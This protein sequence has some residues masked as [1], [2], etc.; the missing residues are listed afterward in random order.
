MS[1]RRGLLGTLIVLLGNLS[2]M[3]ASP[4]KVESYGKVSMR[5]KEITHL[6]GISGLLGWDEMV[7]LPSGSSGSRSAQKEVLAGVLYDKRA[8]PEL[9]SLLSD[10]QGA[11]G[12]DELSDVQKANVRIALQDYQR[13][14]RVPKELV[15]LQARLESDGYN[16]WIRAR[17]ASDFSHFSEALEDWVQ[18]KRQEA[19]Y[20]NPG[21]N[22]YDTLLYAF[23]KGMT[24]SR[25]DEIF[26]EVKSGL[27]PLI[28]ELKN[29]KPP[30]R[31]M[32]DGKYD[33]DSQARLC[34]SIALDLGF[35]VEKGRLDVS[36][37]PFS[38][39]CRFYCSC[40]RFFS[41]FFSFPA[42]M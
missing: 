14:V 7:M 12:T 39:S 6:E 32:L 18:A 11:A 20:I 4:S 9:G 26:E 19:E 5:L 27:V 24:S 31:D 42:A 28:A 17:Q 2:K 36:V 29:G 1:R 33:L 8:D 23:E 30:K 21:G 37:H 41:F 13:L 25:L 10:L 22:T 40:S 3:G 16:K 15:Q 38:K 34:K 35:D